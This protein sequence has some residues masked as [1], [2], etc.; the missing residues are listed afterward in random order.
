MDV[1]DVMN[2][3]YNKFA[4]LFSYSQYLCE[5]TGDLLM[6]QIYGCDPD[7][8]GPCNPQNLTNFLGKTIDKDTDYLTVKQDLELLC[9][10]ECTTTSYDVI[11]N[12]YSPPHPNI[13]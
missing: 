11:H 2:R 4:D 6:N 13:R 9:P 12:S 10:R 7:F 3:R 8:D 1:D 5:V